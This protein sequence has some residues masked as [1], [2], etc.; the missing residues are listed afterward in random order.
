MGI[1]LAVLA[2][3]MGL[4]ALNTGNNLIYLMLSLVLGLA[5]TSTVA[6]IWSLRR[7][8]LQPHLPAEAVRG[9]PFLAGVEAGGRFPFLPQTW[10]DVRIHGLG[11]PVEVSVAVDGREARGTGSTMVTIDRRGVYED[12]TLTAA[13]GYPLDL[14]LYRIRRPIGA[15]LVVLPSFRPLSSLKIPGGGPDGSRDAAAHSAAG[16]GFELRDIREY[17]PADDA[18]HIDWRSTARARRLMVREFER[19]R[20]RSLDLVLDREAPDDEAF[21]PVVERCAALLDLAARSGFDARLLTAESPSPLQ[22]RAAMRYL[23][24]VLPCRPGSAGE[25]PARVARRARPGVQT[26]VLSA[27]PGRATPIE[28]T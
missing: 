4:A 11:R 25:H 27:L 2:L 5:A 8:R 6:S 21:E 22:G 28:V 14:A 13:T 23:A 3:A 1:R 12:L 24:G 17:T 26:V 9:Q 19:E 10:V 16:A 7:L 15:G 20:D 18:R